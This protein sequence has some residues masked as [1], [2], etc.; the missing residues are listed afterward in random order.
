[1]RSQSDL[2][3]MLTETRSGPYPYAGV[4]WFSAPF[5]RDG[6]VT[7]L[8]TLWIEPEISRGVLRFLAATQADRDDASRDEEP[9][10]IV[11][12]M[13][14][15]EMAA[16]REIPF[17]RY[18]GSVDVTPLFLLLAAE[19]HERTG[20]RALIEE[21]WPNLE[22]AADWVERYGDSDGDGFVDYER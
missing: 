3:M 21:L 4:P 18:Y 6:I 19:Y 15:G 7:A 11:H 12:E 14:G 22:A 10:K 13:R 9:G 1:R 16:L 5:G 8:A 2:A 17:G 20:D